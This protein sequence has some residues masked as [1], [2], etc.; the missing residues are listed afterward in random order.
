MFIVLGGQIG[1]IVQGWHSVEAC[2]AA[3]D[4]VITEVKSR[5]GAASYVDVKVRCLEFPNPEKKS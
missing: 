2:N 3:S 4:Q 1:P 5:Q